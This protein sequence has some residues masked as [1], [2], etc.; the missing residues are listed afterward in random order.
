VIRSELV[1]HI[2]D[3]FA[4]PRKQA[5]QAVNAI[6]AEMIEQMASGGRVELRD[7]GTFNVKTYESKMGRNPKTGEDIELPS[8]SLPRFKTGK[9][10]RARLNQAF[11]KENS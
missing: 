10:L 3:T 4:L 2:A 11:E 5:D 8:R 7:F 1:D 6:F 9:G